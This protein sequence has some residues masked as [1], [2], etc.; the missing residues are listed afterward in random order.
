MPMSTNPLL[1]IIV[2]NWNGRDIFPACL[3]SL[4]KVE[5]RPI[6]ILFVD[7]GST[8]D[9]VKLAQGFP[10]I[11]IVENGA[12][13]GYAAGNNRAMRHV[14]ANSKYVCFLNNDVVVTPA[15][16]NDAV[17]HIERD[18]RIGAI[19]CRNMD[20]FHPGI[21]DGLYHCIRKPFISMRRFGQGLPYIDDPLYN[22][23]GY[24][25]S[26]LGASAIFRSELF[27]SLGG[28]DESFFAYY[29]DADLCMRINNSGNRC[30]YV[31]EAVVFHKDRA[32][33]KKRNNDSFYYSERNKLYFIRK[34]YPPSFIAANM[35]RIIGEELWFIIACLRGKHNPAVFLRA[36]LDSLRSLQRYTYTGQP[37]SFDRK[38][39]TELMDRKKIPL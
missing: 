18:A 11:R 34:N 4:A 23:P 8:D 28:F 36:R 2:L 33:F 13:L 5:Y 35:A 22:K 24:V 6:E 14:S 3:E 1:S 15:W 31:P 37:G 27:S 7:N 20:F 25:A 39:I 16:L 38:F 30:L 26:A 21:I 32:S 12:N 17:R 19:A 29:E 10:G 9:S